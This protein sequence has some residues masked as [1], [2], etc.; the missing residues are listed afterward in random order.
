MGNMF[1]GFD[2]PVFVLYTCDRPIDFKTFKLLSFDFSNCSQEK[3][4]GR[5]TPSNFH[6]VNRVS[7]EAFTNFD[8]A[9]DE[10]TAPL[11]QHADEPHLSQEV[12]ET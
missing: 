5:A 8:D 11:L 9:Q 7:N 10:D 3:F 4:S 1:C 12:G 6:Y 2:Q